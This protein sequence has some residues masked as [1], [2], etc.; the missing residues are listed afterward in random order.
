MGE[1]TR[2]S[3]QV[4]IREVG[5]GEE[6][7]NRLQGYA[8]VFDSVSED[9]GFREVIAKGALDNTNMDDVVLN[10]NH[11]N[12]NVLARNNKNEGLGSLNLS[13]DDKGLFF[14]AEPT[15]TTYARDLIENMKAGVLGKC[16]FA[17]RIDW[18]DPDSQA[19]DFSN[20]DFDMRTIKKIKR[21]SDVSIVTSP[22]YESTSSTVYKRAKEDRRKELDHQRTLD[23]YDYEKNKMEGLNNV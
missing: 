23:I 2:L 18:S 19:W 20:D 3:S 1:E 16:S 22:A 9:L 7:Q 10:I 11:N 14:D 15:N 13:V 17:F 12:S 21:I 5:E 6:K 8:L 4:E